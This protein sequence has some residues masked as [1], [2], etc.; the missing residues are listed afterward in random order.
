MGKSEKREL[1]SFL[2][3]AMVLLILIE[4]YCQ[5]R[6]VSVEGVGV[7]IRPIDK[8]YR[9]KS[10]HLDTDSWNLG[11]IFPKRSIPSMLSG[12]EY[13]TH[14][15]RPASQDSRT[16]DRIDRF[17][18]DA[19]G[20]L[21][22]A[23][24][25]PAATGDGWVRVNPGSTPD[26]Y[27]DKIG[28][29]T[30]ASPDPDYPYW[31]YKRTYTTPGT[32]VSLPVNSVSTNHPPFVFANPWELYWENPLELGCNGVIITRMP[33]GGGTTTLANPKLIVMPNGDYFASIR[34]A[35][36]TSATSVWRSVDKGAT[37]TLV[38]SDLQVNQDSLFQ[39][40]GS[41]YLIGANLSGSG[42]TRIYKSSDNGV[43][44]TTATF[45][46]SGGGD[47]PSHVD[48]VNGRLWKAASTSGG[49]GFFSAPVDADLMLES[50]WTLTV[51]KYSSITLANGQRYSSGNEGTLLT[52]KEGILINAGKDDVYRP[53]DGWKDGIS[54]VQPDLTDI[55]KTTYDPDYAGPRLPGSG[56]KY[57]VRYDPVSD[58]YWALTS[59]GDPRTNLNLYSASSVGGRIGDFQLEKTV[60]R[61]VS[62]S[63]HGFNY[64]FMQIDGDDIIFTSRTAWETHRGQAT[65]WHDGNVF[66]FHRIKNFRG[67]SVID[68]D[69]LLH[70][71]FDKMII[72]VRPREQVA[73]TMGLGVASWWDNDAAGATVTDSEQFG[74]Y[75]NGDKALIFNKYNT[76]SYRAQFTPVSGIGISSGTM[77]MS[78]LFKGFLPVPPGES[79]Q[80]QWR[81]GNG[82]LRTSAL[83]RNGGIATAIHADEYT[84][85]DNSD[86]LMGNGI[87][88]IITKFDNMGTSNGYSKTWAIA[89][90]EYD[91][92][93]EA[94]ITE[95]GLDAVAFLQ[96]SSNS[97]TPVTWS[98]SE[99]FRFYLDNSATVLIDEIQIGTTLKSVISDNLAPKP[100][101]NIRAKVEVED[102]ALEWEES[103]ANDLYGYNVY[104]SGKSSDNYIK[105]NH[106]VLIESSFID[107]TVTWGQTYSYVVTAL[108]RSFNESD[109]SDAGSALLIDN[110]MGKIL[111]E[112]WVGVSGDSVLDLTSSV[113]FPNSPDL[114]GYLLNLEGPT[115]WNND[116]GTRIRG[117]IYPPETGYYIFWVAG[118]DNCE[119]WLSGD[120]TPAKAKLIAT[121]PDWTDPQ[122]WEK[123]SSQKSDLIYLIGG[124]KYYIEVLQKEG[125]GGDNVAVA[126]AGPSIPRQVISGEHLSSWHTGTYGNFNNQDSVNMLDFQIL[127]SLWLENDCTITAS[128]DSGGDCAV[129]LIELSGMVENW[130][131]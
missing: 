116:Y 81:T 76:S 63:Y 16:D 51:G 34:H 86:T 97:T 80:L 124:K 126:W 67:Y 12:M 83:T 43:T 74:S 68:P 130:L 10:D 24:P 119:L 103:L 13:A 72:G 35:T 112:R 82:N 79:G 46:S 53:E 127:S 15:F 93:A 109:F 129:N 38:G 58:R 104:R 33:E 56:S 122:Q 66:T 123:F 9:Y 48:V 42:A 14:D 22:I 91:S 18:A 2:L 108:D 95:A 94:G 84:Q 121:V 65:R 28:R 98:E 100:P 117:Y 73:S 31:L 6:R 27:L 105:L 115:D 47:A 69:L 62:T 107:S 52:T 25:S 41:I 45:S 106:E 11:H 118:D 70:E 23:M 128:I 89:P 71:S 8:L 131:K 5:A 26:L 60:L 55:T 113:D 111:Y 77:Y 39:H 78:F 120:G 36:G 59:G 61:G 49:E 19:A 87:F 17:K 44:W 75:S 102:V 37:W 40:K 4:S 57:T 32:W 110:G 101:I 1:S 125:T 99:I 92:L 88:L 96:A 29:S 54:L 64:P 20:D 50:S 90:A 85:P 21:L 7:I 3:L 30:A 114:V